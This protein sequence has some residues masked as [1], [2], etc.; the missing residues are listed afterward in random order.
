M[1][2][3]KFLYEI[4]CVSAIITTSTSS[5]SKYIYWHFCKFVSCFNIYH[6]LN[7][8]LINWFVINAHIFHMFFYLILT[9]IL[10]FIHI[11]IRIIDYWQ[12]ISKF[13]YDDFIGKNILFAPQ[14]ATQ[15][16]LL[17]VIYA[18]F[19][20]DNIINNIIMR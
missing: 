7:F 1:R 6:H 11:Y 14:L 4:L 16:H 3:I 5:H 17:M 20:E 12:I 8:V 15:L 9:I 19:S 13:Y 2:Y 18:T 10:V